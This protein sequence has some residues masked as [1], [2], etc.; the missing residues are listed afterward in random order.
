MR[1]GGQ[2]RVPFSGREHAA[3]EAATIRAHVGVARWKHFRGNSDRR[4]LQW[5]SSLRNYWRCAALV[6]TP[7]FCVHRAS[8]ICLPSSSVC[9]HF[10]VPTGCRD[11]ESACI[12]TGNQHPWTP[13]PGGV[14]CGSVTATLLRS[15]PF[16]VR[17]TCLDTRTVRSCATCQANLTWATDDFGGQSL[18]TG[19]SGT[20]IRAADAVPCQNTIGNGGLRSSPRRGREMRET[21]RHWLMRGTASL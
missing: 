9:T 1:R 20:I 8:P 12:T 3:L 13:L 16:G 2:N 10:S 5:A 17:P 6:R 21:R 4:R 14:S 19:V 11:K 15:S 18:S 7:Y